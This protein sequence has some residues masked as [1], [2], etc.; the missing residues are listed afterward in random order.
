MRTRSVLLYDFICSNE[1]AVANFTKKQT[2]NH[3]YAK[4]AQRS[5]IDHVLV[6]SHMV[7]DIEGCEIKQHMDN[8]SDHYAIVCVFKMNIEPCSM[9]YETNQSFPRTQ[10]SKSGF[11]ALYR[12]NLQSTLDSQMLMNPD[13][14]RDHETQKVIDSLDT[15][16][17]AHESH[18]LGCQEMCSKAGHAEK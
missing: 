13:L 9:P 6:P 15:G 16:Q 8:A 2:I 10:W 1:M 5:Y 7:T 4:G 11:C 12:I 18:A 3:T 14:I 17:H